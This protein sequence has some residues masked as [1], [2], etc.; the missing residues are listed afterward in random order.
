MASFHGEVELIQNWQSTEGNYSNVTANYYAVRDSGSAYSGYETYADC[1][2]DGTHETKTISSFNFSSSNTRVFLGSITKNVYHDGDGTKTVYASFS[3]NTQNSYS[4]TISGSNSLRLTDIPRYANF[5]EHYIS[6]TGLNSISVK[7]NADAGC[8]TVQYSLNGG[9]WTNTSGLTYTISGL[10]PNTN[11]NIR[12]RIKRSDSQLWTTSGYIYATTKDIARLTS[13]PKFNLGSN[14]TIQY[15]NPSNASI[16]AGIYDVNGKIEYASYRNVSGSS[17]TFK[18]TD[19]ELDRIY[20]SMGKENSITLRYYLA[21]SNN[22]YRDSRN[23]VVK[24]T[25]NQKTGRV[26]ISDSWKR[27]KKWVN[28]NGTWKRCVRWVNVN[29]TW[30]RCI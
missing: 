9:G 23:V 22:Q 5:T 7:W 11:Y 15:S 16:E 30:R 28:V 8:D 29:G 3:W 20:K 24:L 18:F 25:G 13:Y 14:T 21:T 19:D 12:T 6:S 10:N 27:A 4:G 2:L 17:Y 26:N 1:A